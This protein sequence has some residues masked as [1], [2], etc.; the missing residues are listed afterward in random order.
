MFEINNTLDEIND[1]CNIVYIKLVNMKIRNKN[2][3]VETDEGQFFKKMNRESMRYGTTKSETWKVVNILIVK[4]AEG[5]GQGQKKMFDERK[6]ERF[7]NLMKSMNPQ[8][9]ESQQIPSPKNKKSTESHIL[10][11]IVKS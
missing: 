10:D 3:E 8:I 11:P 4:V 2:Y 7:L 9:Q 6:A 1:K 5:G